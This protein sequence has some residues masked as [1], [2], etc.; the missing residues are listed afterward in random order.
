[1]RV[2]ELRRGIVSSMCA[3]AYIYLY[4][5]P[6]LTR[7]CSCVIKYEVCTCRLIYAKYYYY[8]VKNLQRVGADTE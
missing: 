4:L 5:G 7:S 8:R 6:V 2:S 3:C 1:M